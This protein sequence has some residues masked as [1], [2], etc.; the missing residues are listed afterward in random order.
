M[1]PHVFEGPNRHYIRVF[2]DAEKLKEMLA[3]YLIGD[4]PTVLGRVYGVDHT[5]IIFQV[6]KAGVWRL[7]GRRY[8]KSIAVVLPPI[9]KATTKSRPKIYKY[10]PKFDQEEKKCDG[11]MYAEYAAQAAQR[12]MDR[13]KNTGPYPASLIGK[14]SRRFRPK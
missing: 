14:S 12:M 10:Q 9:V 7:G 6:K 11:K 1:P 5:S 3:R 8:L 13:F 4:T 2:D